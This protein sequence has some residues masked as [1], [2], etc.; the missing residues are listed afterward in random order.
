MDIAGLLTCNF[1]EF[2]LFLSCID[3]KAKKIYIW[4][5]CSVYTNHSEKEYNI[6]ILFGLIAIKKNQQFTQIRIFWE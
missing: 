4:N 2:W 1:R 6:Y 3:I 5:I